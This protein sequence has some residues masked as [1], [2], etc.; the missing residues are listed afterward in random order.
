MN[1]AQEEQYQFYQTADAPGTFR[2][3]NPDHNFQCTHSADG[4]TITP[5][6]DSSDLLNP[7][8]TPAWSVQYQAISLLLDAQHVP[9]ESTAP[10]AFENQSSANRLPGCNEWFI[11]SSEGL[12]H[13]FTVQQPQG[14]H[15]A[16][17]AVQIAVNATLT[18]T[19]NGTTK[20]VEFQDPAG[21]TLLGYRDLHVYDRTGRELSSAMALDTSGVTPSITL[22]ADVHDALF[23]ITIDPFTY[24]QEGVQQMPND[25]SP[26]DGFGSSSAECGD[27]FVVG[28][29]LQGNGAAYVYKRTPGTDD[30]VQV[31]KLEVPVGENPGTDDQFS[32]SLAFAEDEETGI[33]YL[34]VGAQQHN[35]CGSAFVYYLAGAVWTFLQRLQPAD[36]TLGAYFACSIAVY[37]TMI[38]FGALAQDG[39][40]AVY[41]FTLLLAVAAFALYQKV[42]DFLGSVGDDFGFDVDLF[43]LTLIV[44]TPGKDAQSGMTTYDRAGAALVFNAALIG[45]LFALGY[46]IFYNNNPGDDQNMGSSVLAWKNLIFIGIPGAAK[47]VVWSLVLGLWSQITFF[48][49]PAG[50]LFGAYMFINNFGDLGIS[51]PLA[52][53]T[54]VIVAGA[55]YMFLFNSITGT[56]P[57]TGE[58]TVPS[59]PDPGMNFGGSFVLIASSSPWPPTTSSVREP[60][61]NSSSPPPSSPSP[62]SSSST[63]P[64]NR[65][66]TPPNNTSS[67]FSGTLTAIASPTSWNTSSAPTP[68]SSTAI[69]SPPSSAMASSRSSSPSASSP[70]MPPSSS[71]TPS[72]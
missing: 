7:E 65:S 42:F 58:K 28:A 41:I 48:T 13:G 6:P 39:K 64:S 62:P 47:V 69:P 53:T 30:F 4:L 68:P 29:P 23:P 18:P 72:A 12:Q 54:A 43:G 14:N 51:A 15:P 21:R 32:S 38:A 34:I 2:A 49:G 22:Q 70:S 56:Y 44:G 52:L 37:G 55:I 20:T 50:S 10:S 66:T 36:L 16:S 60:S 17:L 31:D 59:N 9:L 35:G 61:S 24:M 71:N 40:G 19:F 11:N 67:E 27:Y 1:Q 33:K 3:T 8:A 5:R 45:G 46:A 26:G 57:S 63:S 25:L